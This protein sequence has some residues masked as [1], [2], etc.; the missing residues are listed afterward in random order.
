MPGNPSIDEVPVV[1][2]AAP[3]VAEGDLPAGPGVHVP[4]ERQLYIRKNVELVRHGYAEGARDATRLGLEALHGH[5]RLS[6]E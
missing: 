3:V 2:D 5:T 1:V 6:V 4:E